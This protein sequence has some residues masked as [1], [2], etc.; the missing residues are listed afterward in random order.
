[1]YLSYMIQ[2]FRCYFASILCIPEMSKID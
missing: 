1:L 2:I